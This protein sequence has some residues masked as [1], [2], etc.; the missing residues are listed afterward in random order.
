MRNVVPAIR[1]QEEKY[2]LMLWA[3]LLVPAQLIR[4]KML[5]L[6]IVC[7]YL[8]NLRTK[9]CL[10]VIWIKN[11]PSFISPTKCQCSFWLKFKQY[12]QAMSYS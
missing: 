1:A 4:Q 2:V 6:A 11:M 8:E 12:S 10:K 3:V 5:E 7:I 9:L